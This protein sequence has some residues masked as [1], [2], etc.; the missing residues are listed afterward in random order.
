MRSASGG[1]PFAALKSI[2]IT[3]LTMAQTRLQL[4]GNEL[5]TEKNLALRQ[6]SLVLAMVACAGLGLLLAVVLALSLL[7]EQRVLVLSL[8][9]VLFLGAAAGCYA[10]LRRTTR[11]SEGVFASSLAELQEDLRQLKA[12]AEHGQKSP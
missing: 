10:A 1:G 4:L 11:S 2:P 3:L 12:A 6:L 8:L 7:W 9:S 5:L